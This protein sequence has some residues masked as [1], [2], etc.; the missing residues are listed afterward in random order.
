MGTLLWGQLCSESP[1]LG[2]RGGSWFPE[3]GFLPGQ[4]R[5]LGLT[6]P[7]THPSYAGWPSTL[8]TASLASPASQA[9]HTRDPGPTVLTWFNG[10]RLPTCVFERDPPLSP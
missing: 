7:Q 9:S 6:V 2:V 10:P 1:G 4:R 3:C 5:L 8:L